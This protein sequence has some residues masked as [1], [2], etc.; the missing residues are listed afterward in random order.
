MYN[1]LSIDTSTNEWIP[2]EKP[3]CYE[4]DMLKFFSWYRVTYSALVLEFSRYRM[5]F[6]EL[7]QQAYNFFGLISYIVVKLGKDLHAFFL[8]KTKPNP[9]IATRL[10]LDKFAWKRRGKFMF[11]T[12]HKNSTN[13]FW[14]SQH[15]MANIGQLWASWNSKLADYLP[16]FALR[17]EIDWTCRLC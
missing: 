1:K 10:C 5:H 15:S 8:K 17:I 2:V 3:N 16:L 6:T 7:I 11:L 9:E 4:R 13:I 12:L 14:I